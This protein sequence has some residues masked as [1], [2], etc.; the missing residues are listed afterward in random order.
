MGIAALFEVL[1]G[2]GKAALFAGL[3][4]GLAYVLLNP[5]AIGL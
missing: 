5:G 4:L 3:A 1:W 2:L